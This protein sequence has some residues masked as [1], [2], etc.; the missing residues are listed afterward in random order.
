MSC[1]GCNGLPGQQTQV[2]GGENWSL[3]SDVCEESLL[4][5]VMRKRKLD[6]NKDLK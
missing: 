4:I 5:I 3:S 2:R 1:V 6:K